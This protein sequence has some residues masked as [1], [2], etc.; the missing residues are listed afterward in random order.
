MLAKTKEEADELP[1]EVDGRVRESCLQ[2]SRF[3][4]LEIQLQ[5][6][7]DLTHG[8][9]VLDVGDLA[10]VR[11]NAIDTGTATGVV[12]TEAIDRMVEYVV[13][14]HPELHLHAFS[15]SEVLRN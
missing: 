11:T 10:I 14:I 12:C 9:A 3:R 7:L 4:V 8:G 6:E 13:R 5:T 2:P 15:D 1:P